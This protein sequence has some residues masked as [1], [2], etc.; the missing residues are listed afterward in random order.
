MPKSDDYWQARMMALED[1]QYRK[2][3]EYYEDIQK[4]FKRA[5]M[6]IQADIEEWYYRLADNNEISYA[7]AKELLKKGELEEFKWTLEQYIQ[8]GR[9]NAVSEEWMKELENASARYHINY[10]E[11]IKMQIR[12]HAEI[13]YAEYESRTAEFL[14]KVFKEQFYRTAYEIAKGS[15]VAGNLAE[16]DIRRINLV[17]TTPW[18]QDGR[19]FSDRI[20]QNK[21]KLVRELH[22]EL[23]QCII[24]GE[25]PDKAARRLADSM[26][27]K[28]KQARTLIYTESAAIAMTA[29]R[30]C[31]EE[32][33]V[34]EYEVVETLDSITCSFCQ[35]MDGKHFPLSD[36]QVGITAPPFHPNCRGCTCPYFN[37]EFIA[38][39]K[40]SARNKEGDIYYVPSDMNYKEWKAT[41]VGSNSQNN[42]I[43]TPQINDEKIRDANKEFSQILLTNKQT[44]YRDKM[45]LYSGATE[46]QFNENLAVPFAYNPLSDVIEYNSSAPNYSMYDMNFV[47]AHE[48]SH[49]IDIRE[50][51]S[52]EN[53]SFV[54]AVEIC[55][56]KVYDNTDKIT[57]WFSDNGKYSTDM[58]LSDIFSA[59]SEGSLNDVLYSGHMPEYWKEDPENQYL[60]IFANIA[61]IDLLNYDSKAEFDGILEELYQAYKELTE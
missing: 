22:T 26:G 34:E 41:F 56:Q 20:W 15:G 52:W 36:Y 58:A 7:A 37:D 59:L 2:S 23:T 57:E 9:E 24:R 38:A 45:I 8:K 60:E 19:N 10:L 5:Q 61:S 16:L 12:Q 3:A 28:A 49:R 27:V 18:A 32:L 40:R 33:G 6:N 30:D 14:G 1:E 50:I 29:Q 17:L 13:L 44:S 53:T 54:K 43:Q 21:D 48:L 31:F 42:L 11:A 25:N 4:Q 51:H 55:R 47:Q 39:E 46:Y 35:D